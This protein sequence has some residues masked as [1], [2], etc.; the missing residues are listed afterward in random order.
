ML[1]HLPNALTLT[2]L[3]CGCCAFVCTL[4]GQPVVAALFTAASFACDY[5]DGMAARAL[6]VSGPLGKELDSLA[7]VISFGAVPGAML[8]MMLRESLCGA[9][10]TAYPD[11]GVQPHLCYAALPAFILSMFSGMRLGKFNLDP[12]QAHYF[13]GLSTPA[14]TVLVLGLR[15][16][17]WHDRFGLRDTLQNPW[18]LF[19]L[20]GLLSWL[21]VSEIPMFGMK[22]KKLDLKSNALLLGF[23]ALFLVGLFFLKELAFSLVILFYMVFSIVYKNKV[24]A[25]S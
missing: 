20:V 10:W 22:I 23:A 18:L 2:N 19:P 1:K 4:Y 25:V 17:A 3:F 14:C 11:A 5:A 7:D 16:G 21:L 13:I 6:G 12:R 8:Y 9:G 15:L 24:V